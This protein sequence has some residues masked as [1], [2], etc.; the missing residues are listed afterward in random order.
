[1]VIVEGL[2]IKA[3]RIPKKQL[4]QTWE[5]LTDKPYPKIKALILTDDDFNHVI[6]HRQCPEDMLREIEE[7]G[8]VLSTKGTDACIFNGDNKEKADYIILV[9]ENPYHSL[10]EI[11]AHELAHIIRGDL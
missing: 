6:E 9:R 8:R 5:N 3:K 10:E 11:I 4:Q 7:W 1:M 2:N